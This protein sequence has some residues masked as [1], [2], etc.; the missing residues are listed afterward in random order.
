MFARSG[1]SCNSPISQKQIHRSSQT[2]QTA[3][4]PVALI[5]GTHGGGPFPYARLVCMR[6][7][8]GSFCKTHY[9]TF[10]L[11][12]YRCCKRLRHF[13]IISVE[14]FLEEAVCK[15]QST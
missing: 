13:L 9:L 14:T 2:L 12:R 4:M 5:A 11:C 8:S 3:Y 1:Y 6:A 7:R 15:K 10:I